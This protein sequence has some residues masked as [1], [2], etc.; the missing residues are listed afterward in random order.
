MIGVHK[1]KDLMLLT[2]VC[3]DGCNDCQGSRAKEA[4]PK[5]TNE[6]GLDVLGSSDANGKNSEP[7]G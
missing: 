6:D 1:N 5:A 3:E 7:E 2:Y 4:I